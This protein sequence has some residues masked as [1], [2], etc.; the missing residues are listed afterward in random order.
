[1]R[2]HSDKTWLR[3]PQR[4]TRLHAIALAVVLLLAL[5]IPE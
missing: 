2:D 3:R 1:M 5:C 4:I